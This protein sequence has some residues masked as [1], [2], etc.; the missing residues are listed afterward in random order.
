M[1]GSAVGTGLSA[2]P[3]YMDAFYRRLSEV[4]GE[5]VRP[6]EN[7]FDGFQNADTIDRGYVSVEE[8]LSSLGASISRRAFSDP[9]SQNRS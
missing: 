2:A 5:P 8:S 9:A 6:Y 4:V 3:G 7:L 1:G